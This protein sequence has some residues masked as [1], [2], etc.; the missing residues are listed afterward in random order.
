[1]VLVVKEK[2]TS[3]IAIDAWHY[4]NRDFLGEHRVRV[5]S[6]DFSFK[7]RISLITNLEHNKL[8]TY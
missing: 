2:K 3:V 4:T 1:M 7:E 8:N 5:K 6:Q